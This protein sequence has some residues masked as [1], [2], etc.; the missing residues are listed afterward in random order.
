MSWHDVTRFLHTRGC[1][2]LTLLLAIAAISI[3]W[4]LTSH[5]TSATSLVT[6]IVINSLS[7][8]L[9][10]LINKHYNFL[11]G[12]TILMATL[13]LSMLVAAPTL[14]VTPWAGPAMCLAILAL[15]FVLFS[16]FSD[17]GT[18]RQLLLLF[19]ILATLSLVRIDYVWFIPIFII[20]VIQMRVLDLK[21]ILAII[22]G[23]AT[24]L[25]IAIP[26]G[27]V[28]P[29]TLRL[30]ALTLPEANLDTET[31][32]LMVIAG[33]TIITGLG[34][35]AA[36]IIKVLSYNAR[37]RSMNGFFTILF[38]GTTLLTLIDFHSMALYY[39][40]LAA[41]SAYQGAHFFSNRRQP[42]S[43]IAI[44][45]LIA[46]YWGAFAWSTIILLH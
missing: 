31:L 15:C 1:A 30:P 35:A 5:D 13:F 3:G 39:P 6:G 36:N 23:L 44:L 46:L 25:W 22:M 14:W 43:A 2:Q 42:G 27:L 10:T 9:L 40:L 18:R 21:T 32:T 37:A 45:L 20:G 11:R 19:A 8:L 24:P 17:T 41:M 34:F 26:T 28:D 7:A 16:T 12:D 33:I 4:H 38:L 29:T